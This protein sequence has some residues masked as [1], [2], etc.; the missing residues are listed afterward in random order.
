VSDAIRFHREWITD[1]DVVRAA[2]A[3]HVA[4]EIRSWPAGFDTQVGQMG[5]QMSGG[6]RQRIALARA[7]AGS[8]ELV[9]LDE[10]TS[11]LDPR[12]ERLITET[13]ER[14]RGSMTL[15]VIAHR[16]ATIERAGQVIEIEDGRVVEAGPLRDNG[17]ATPVHQI[18]L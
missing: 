8:P 14:L 6:Q 16:H 1:D 18:A 3:A 12:S 17:P 11:A 9:L 10:P 4:D 7:L 15:V 13:L 5:E 2:E